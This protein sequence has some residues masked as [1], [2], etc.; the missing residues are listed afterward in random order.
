MIKI[1]DFIKDATNVYRTKGYIVK[2]VIGIQYDCKENNVVFSYDTFYKR[3]PKRDKEYEIFSATAATSTASAC[4]LPCTPE[5]ISTE[6][7]SSDF[8]GF[9]FLSSLPRNAPDCH[10]NYPFLVNTCPFGRPRNLCRFPLY[11]RCTRTREEK[12]I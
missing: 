6:S 3:T 11:L 8:R 5:P 7:E 12:P 9:L 2:Q 4:P 1:P 10:L